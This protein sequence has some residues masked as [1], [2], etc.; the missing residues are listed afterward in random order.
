MSISAI[1]NIIGAV[2][3]AL[4]NAGL[5]FFGLTCLSGAFF[6]GCPFR[7]AFSSAIQFIF[8]IPWKL[9][10]WILH[11]RCLQLPV[12][13]HRRRLPVDRR[14]QL[15]QFA[16]NAFLGCLPMTV[17]TIIIPLKSDVNI[18]GIWSSLFF[19][20]AA[21]LPL[22]FIAQQ[23]ADH[24][25]QKYKISQLALWGFLPN[26]VVMSSVLWFQYSVYSTDIEDAIIL[27]TISVFG[28]FIMCLANLIFGKMSKS[29]ANTG[30]IDAI[31]W[32]LKT[33]PPP[34][35]AEFFKKAGQMTVS[36]S[37]GSHYRPRLL[38]SLMP[39]LTLL[40]ISHHLP[41]HPSSESDTPSPSSNDENPDSKREL[42]NIEIYTACLARLSDFRDSEGSFICLW[43][44]TMQHPELE[45]PLVD[46][47][48]Q[49]ANLDPR[50]R[51]H[52][53]LRSAAIKVLRNYRLGMEGQSVG[54]PA[55]LERYGVA[56]GLLNVA[57][58]MLTVRVGWLNDRE[59][60]GDRNLQEPVELELGTHVEPPHSSGD[61]EEA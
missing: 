34:N 26:L 9:F 24:Y 53:R 15:I 8:E 58:S 10:K 7:S 28:T 44:D 57:L 4:F 11:E 29:M 1:Q 38:E 14:K 22:A 2:V 5:L 39:F 61:I 49:F 41:K 50:H 48:V 54:V 43:E 42:E 6:P 45:P 20:I 30:E 23:K 32:L 36:K 19:L 35:S 18:T 51:F 16:N 17:I 21:G 13:R 60:Q 52:D 56:T 33:A 46:K 3:A 40:I 55:A 25:P 37:R 12:P 27:T 31:A 59:E 47:L